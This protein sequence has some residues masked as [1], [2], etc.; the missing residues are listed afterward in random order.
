MCTVAQRLKKKKT[1][2]CCIHTKS[3]YFNNIFFFSFFLSSFPFLPVA[4]LYSV[5]TLC[6]C[7]LPL[8]KPQPNA[9]HSLRSP[10]LH[11]LLSTTS[12]PAS[13]WVCVCVFRSVVGSGLVFSNLWAFWR[14][15]WNFRGYFVYSVFRCSYCGGGGEDRVKIKR[16]IRVWRRKKKS[17]KE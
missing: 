15:W 2:L 3:E 12:C 5:L 4:P 11:P 10:Q 8:T 9:D 6:F 1:I 7:P 14:N 17:K 16:S 13:M